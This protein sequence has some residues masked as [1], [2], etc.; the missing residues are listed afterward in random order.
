[1]SK[2]SHTLSEQDQ[3]TQQ[4]NM[5]KDQHEVGLRVQVVGCTGLPPTNWTRK[6]DPYV[7]VTLNGEEHS[8]KVVKGSV[9]PEHPSEGPTFTFPINQS[10]LEH[11]GDLL[12][13]VWRYG[14][15]LPDDYI[16]EVAIPFDEWFKHHGPS[17][18][19]AFDDEGNK[20]FPM[21]IMSKKKKNSKAGDIQVKIGFVPVNGTST[22]P[23]YASIFSKLRSSPPKEEIIGII[24]LEVQSA[25]GLPKWKNVLRTS[26]D[27][28]PVCRV[29][30][31]GK[32]SS[33]HRVQKSLEPVWNHK[34][35]LRVHEAETNLDINFAVFDNDRITGDDPIG[36]T[37]LA[38][39]ELMDTLALSELMDQGPNSTSKAM[40]YPELAIPKD[41]KDMP[42][43]E[44]PLK[45]QEPNCKPVLTVRAK[46]LRYD[47]LRQMFW[48]QLLHLY[49][50]SRISRSVFE[51]MLEPLE[52]QPSPA[53]I[54]SFFKGSENGDLTFDEV[55]I[56]LE[57]AVHKPKEQRE[58]VGE[59]GSGSGIRKVVEQILSPKDCP[60]CKEPMG[61]RDIVT[62][63][64]VCPKN[65]W[66]ELGENMYS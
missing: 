4:T 10:N 47:A 44:L 14:R 26:L 29:S 59:S 21:A 55:I 28:D 57:D 56:R 33:T 27:V 37:S 58:H 40:I 54:D 41:G 36:S 43:F 19:F 53:T 48:R 34:L 13:T 22:T 25:K 38:L 2:V 46:Y 20:P 35:L 24:M 61:E 9:N 1:M 63:S 23:D 3:S 15:L 6:S 5:I 64:A 42:S 17:P 60:L 65:D 50:E 16:G 32:S 49:D 51:K 11:M 39:S 52:S 18:S 12:F 7:K 45:S 30:F 31:G 8:T 62:H 66:A